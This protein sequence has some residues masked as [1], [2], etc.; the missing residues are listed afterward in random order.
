MAELSTLAR[1]YA[2]AAFEYARSETASN[3]NALSEWLTE[4]QL[5]AAVV[6]DPAVQNMLADPAM[7]TEAQSR[8]FVDICGDEL[9]ETRQRFVHVLA[10]NRRLGLAPQIL[11]Q[12]AQLK[13]LR[14][15]SVD[16]EMVS[17][18]DVPDAIRDRIAAA[19]GKRLER[20]VVVTTNTDSSLLGGVLIRAGDLVIDGSV[21]GRLNK[22][23][24]TL[25]N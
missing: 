24:E 9:A 3:A 12:F 22:L 17:A 2:K 10:D 23:A 15:Q 14:E 21:R 8:A 16:V 6:S 11:L 18:F 7:T 25:T 19:L 4:L 13:A 5:I 20:E 1:P